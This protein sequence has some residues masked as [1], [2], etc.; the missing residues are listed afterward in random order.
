[1]HGDLL[2]GLKGHLFFANLSLNFEV[3]A[4]DVDDCCALIS[5]SIV[6]FVDCSC[7]IYIYILVDTRDL[8]SL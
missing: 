3:V 5:S 2:N 8:W 6:V 4:L 1:M 7:Y